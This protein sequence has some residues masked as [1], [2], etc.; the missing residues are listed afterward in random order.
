MIN[1]G[2]AIRPLFSGIEGVWDSQV[3]IGLLGWQVNSPVWVNNCSEHGLD[4]SSVQ[5]FKD[6]VN[7]GLPFG[8]FLLDAGNEVI[9]FNWGI[10]FQKSQGRLCVTEVHVF[11]GSLNV[12]VVN[13]MVLSGLSHHL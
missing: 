9:P 7:L 4:F 10:G 2:I 11:A 12:A 5:S 13:F 8:T 3:D 1:D 6:V